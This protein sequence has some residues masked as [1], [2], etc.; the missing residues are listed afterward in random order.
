MF[1]KNR[2]AIDLGTDN[3][4]VYEPSRGIIFNEPTCV[5]LNK[6]SGKTLCIGHEAKK[7]LGKTPPHL[8][9]I[10]PL[11]QGAIANLD[12]TV[13]F[14]KH[15]IKMLMRKRS[16]FGPAIAV[17]VPFDLTR[18]ERNAVKSAGLQSGAGSVVMI[19]DPY[20]AAIGAGIDFHSPDGA[21]LLDIGS[22]VTEISLL[23]C[24]GIVASHSVRSAGWDFE[25]DII[26]HFD[27]VHRE[28]I[29]SRDAE[30]LKLQL[31]R[32]DRGDTTEVHA[33]SRDNALP[34]VLQIPKCEVREALKPSILRLGR[35]VKTFMRTLPPDFAP[36]LR[37]NG[38]YL[39]GGSAL[40]GGLSGHLENALGLKTVLG[41]DPLLEIA[42]GAGRIM[43]DRK[44][45]AHLSAR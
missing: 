14:L 43:E 19:K 8:P 32:H 6:S 15:L 40:L 45:F 26:H 20:S 39:T 37:D 30:L 35:F 44:L 11:S 12:A 21:L 2:Y 42:L 18:Y 27:S 23:G 22:G 34:H 33:L 3:T 1:S 17:S 9:V 31:S 5:T 41:R 10:R 7:M 13:L 25:Q 38:L 29:S 28:R 16:L 36:R 4:I 24:G